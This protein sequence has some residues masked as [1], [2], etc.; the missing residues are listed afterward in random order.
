[1]NA[2]GGKEVARNRNILGGHA[3]ACALAHR[4][5][6][7]KI[8][9]HRHADA[10]ARDAQIQRL[11]EACCANTA[12]PLGQVLNQGV[13]AGDAQISPTLLH[14]GGHIGGAYHQHPNTGLAGVE[15]QLA[16]GVRV[17]QHLD[18]SGAQQRQSFLKNTALGQG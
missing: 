15:N 8:R 12:A 16:R 11:V 14:I 1:M 6:V 4:K 5:G 7:V 17:V 3:Q 2:L 13:A 9:S 10:A 18:A